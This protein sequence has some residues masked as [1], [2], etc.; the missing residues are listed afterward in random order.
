MRGGAGLGGEGDQ[1]QA[2]VGGE[3]H[4]FEGEV[5]VAHDRMVNALDAR[6]VLA[7]VV[8][9]QSLRNRSLRVESSPTRSLSCRSCGDRPASARRTATICRARSPSPVERL[10]AWGRGRRTG[11]KF[12]GRRAPSNISEKRARPRRLVAMTSRRPFCTNTGTV[13]IA[14]S[15]LLHAGGQLRLRG[16]ARRRCG[17]APAL[18]VRIRSWRCACSASSSC[19]ARLIPSITASETPVAL[20]RSRR[21]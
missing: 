15:S 10:R 7:D 20:P 1:L 21:M 16:R 6:A 13:D 8:G 4:G 14:S 2:A 9:A 5:E 11:R 18:A 19:R 3:V 17:W 12:A